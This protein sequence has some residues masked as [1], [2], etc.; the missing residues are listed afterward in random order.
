M[1]GFTFNGISSKNR[2]IKSIRTKR[3][4]IPASKHQIIELP[5]AEDAIL[6]PDETSKVIT[7]EVQCFYEIPSN[8]TVEYYGIIL[9]TYFKHNN[10]KR[11]IF[12]DSPDFYYEAIVK[13]EIVIDDVRSKKGKFTVRF[14]CRGNRKGVEA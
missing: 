4:L 2:N 1:S 5:Q 14:T 8:Y 11:L 9:N 10:W 3:V 7:I 6:I 12:D 13:D